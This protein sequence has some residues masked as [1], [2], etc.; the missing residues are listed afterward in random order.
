MIVQGIGGIT[1]G[2]TDFAPPAN[3]WFYIDH[4]QRQTLTTGGEFSFWKNA[5][6]NANVV[7]GSGFL[8]A[9]GRQPVHAQ[10][11]LDIAFGKSVGENLSATVSALNITNSRFLLGRESSFGGTHYN[12]FWCKR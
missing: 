4:D 5:C 3:E 11:M 10:G 8:D 7:A 2:M 9:A 1:A 6:V 12:G